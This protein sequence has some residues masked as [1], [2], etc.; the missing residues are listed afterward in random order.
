M[1]LG[2]LNLRAR[3]YVILGYLGAVVGAGFVSG[4][5]VVQF[6]VNYGN[7][8]WWG[9]IIAV[10]LFAVLGG[11]LMHIA[12]QHNISNYQDLLSL[13]FNSKFANIIEL[14]L[15]VFLF[16]GISI[17]L[18]ASGAIFSEHL[19]LP[20]FVGIL[21]MSTAVFIALL[22]GKQGLV[23]S[24]N[25]LVPLK[26]IMLIAINLYLAFGVKNQAV[27]NYLA[28]ID[29]PGDYKWLAAAVLYIAYNFTLVMV[30][31]VEY[32]SITTKRQSIRGAML[33]GVFLGGMVLLNFWAL[34][35][36]IPEVFAY[37]IPMLFA[38]G[39]ISVSAKYCYLLILW[40][41]IL[42]TAIANTYG[43]TQRMSKYSGI[44]FKIMLALSLGLA[45]PLSWQSFS[46]LVGLVYPIFGIVGTI[47]ISAL[48]YQHIKDIA[49]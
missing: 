36:G 23:A 9:A 30:V 3:I 28:L 40:L 48:I 45:L 46:N 33:G 14:L 32:Q 24:Y 43:F 47:I 4:Q 20:K 5:E 18:S 1:C 16:L 21:I 35:K 8:G 31:L 39:K 29:N 7:Q 6:F 49:L 27:F 42:T 11:I 19:A 26:I 22:S 38:A 37:E 15:A 25:Y 2:G 12:H 44:N 13:L 10:L 34:A 41:G 17:M